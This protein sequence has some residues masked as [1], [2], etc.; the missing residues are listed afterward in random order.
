MASA[1]TYQNTQHNSKTPKDYNI[2]G[3][4]TAIIILAIVIG[5]GRH[6]YIPYSQHKHLIQVKTYMMKIS[7]LEFRYLKQHQKFASTKELFNLNNDNLNY[8]TNGYNINLIIKPD[9]TSFA[10]IATRELNNHKYP[11]CAKMVLVANKNPYSFDDH[12]NLHSF[13]ADGK[14]TKSCW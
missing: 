11:N 9:Q 13:D 7:E 14:E 2:I 1:N 12:H 6:Y 4:I 8:K 10:I 3:Y 5:I